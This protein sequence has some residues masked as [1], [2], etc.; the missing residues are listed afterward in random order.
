MRL[1]DALQFRNQGR[2][3]VWLMR[4]AGRYMPSYR[5][6]RKKYPFLHLCHEPELIC[7]VT[8]LPIDELNVDAAILF[9]DILMVPEAL[10][11][12][13]HFDEAKGPI[14]DNALQ[15]SS[16]LSHFSLLQVEE[17]LH[18]LPTAIQNLKRSL[19]VPLIGFA[20]APFTLASYIIEGN[21]SRD[22]KKTKRWM[23]EDAEGFSK[24]I[25]FLEEAVIRS[26]KLQE[27][28]GCD[29]LQIF[30][31]WAHVLSLEHFKTWCLTPLQKIV[32]QMKKPVIYFC[33]G[34]SYRA[35][36]ISS[37]G[38]KAISIDWILPIEEIRRIVPN[39]PLQG[40]LDPEALYLPKSLLIQEVK[41]MLQQMR[42]DQGYIFNL[43]HG[44][45]PDVPYENVRALV[46]TIQS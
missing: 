14:I 18:F 32:S 34:S 5:D 9:S 37:T 43:G 42:E 40:N 44:I 12:H 1:L 33:K 46:E 23:Y 15:T 7:H 11:F 17:R 35:A 2:P 28:A 16:D 10:G 29:V 19:S 38:V 3:P 6:L 24:I 8:S 13:V 22:L 26:L 39:I 27:E 4:Q 20:G 31:S 25:G 36:L 30:D 41:K 45:L 21:T